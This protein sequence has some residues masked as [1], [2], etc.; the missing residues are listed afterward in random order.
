MFRIVF[1]CFLRPSVIC[2]WIGLLPAVLL[3][4]VV[5]CAVEKGCGIEGENTTHSP[6]LQS[7]CEHC[8]MPVIHF[9][10]SVTM[11]IVLVS[12]VPTIMYRCC[13]VLMMYK[14]LPSNYLI[15]LW[16]F[17]SNFESCFNQNEIILQFVLEKLFFSQQNSKNNC[18]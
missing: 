18:I 13:S 15:Y 17:L 14:S 6:P 4:W 5:L 2:N 10:W 7:C 9:L 12:L 11:F 16:K 3:G 1:A 8:Y